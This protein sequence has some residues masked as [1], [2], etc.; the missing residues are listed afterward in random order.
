MKRKKNLK[1]K[2]SLTDSSK[3]SILQEMQSKIDGMSLNEA[4]A[5]LEVEF[6]KMINIQYRL[7]YFIGS[8]SERSEIEGGSRACS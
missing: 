6:T 3:C 4:Y 5:A 1:K 2:I 7:Y 8:E